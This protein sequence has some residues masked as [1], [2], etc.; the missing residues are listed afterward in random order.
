MVAKK[1]IGL[2]LGLLIGLISVALNYATI[3]TG[4]FSCGWIGLSYCENTGGICPLAS[5]T[6][7]SIF[8]VGPEVLVMLLSPIL[9][10]VYDFVYSIF[11]KNTGLL[12]ILTSVFVP[13]TALFGHLVQIFIKKLL[14]L[15]N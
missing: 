10:P 7:T 15:K 6:Y 3:K 14:E 2:T 1:W 11:P 4:C 9:N 13:F 12:V 8:F 5:N